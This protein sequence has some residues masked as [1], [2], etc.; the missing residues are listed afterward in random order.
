LDEIAAK[1]E[2]LDKNQQSQVATAVAGT[3]QANIFRSTMAN[4]DMVLEQTVASQ[5]ASGST[6]ERMAVYTE[7]LEA[8][9]NRLKTSWTALV[10]DLDLQ[11]IFSEAI[12]LAT[13]A[14]EV[15]DYILT[16]IPVVSELVQTLLK[17]EAVNVVL[18]GISKA[19]N[20]LLGA[21]G[22]GGLFSGFL[23]F[24]VVLEGINN[25]MTKTVVGF[26][27]GASASTILG[28][29]IGTMAKQF[30]A[31]GGG[32]TGIVSAI[33]SFVSLHPAITAVAVALGAAYAAYKIWDANFNPE[34][35]IENAKEAY[36][37]YADEITEIN[38]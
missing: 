20:H 30:T 14:I 36:Q 5:E 34:T 31:A 12:D 6:M 1:W 9:V 24:K 28:N 15:L 11:G 23:D 19:A 37:Q 22:I 7:S 17:L 10:N 18:G 16:K 8:K 13:R 32:I 25:G 2:T 33:S 29:T 38:S 3:N 4:Y 27:K 21:D 26:T 35:K